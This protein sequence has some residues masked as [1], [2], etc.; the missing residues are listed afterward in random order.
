MT[1]YSFP[2]YEEALQNG[3]RSMDEESNGMG[4]SEAAI[5]HFL[6]GELEDKW[7]EIGLDLSY[8]DIEENSEVLV[9][10]E[11]STAVIYMEAWEGVKLPVASCT[12]RVCPTHS[13]GD[14]QQGVRNY[15]P[16]TNPEPEIHRS[17]VM[18]AYKSKYQ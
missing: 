6:E 14:S 3:H 7:S 2:R 9:S 12:V 11:S 10:R 15:K 5:R 8:W 17:N 18:M 1:H 4:E 16:P 13:G